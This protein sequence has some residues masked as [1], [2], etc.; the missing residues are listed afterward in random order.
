[1]AAFK[2]NAGLMLEISLEEA[3][4]FI[5]S[6]QFLGSGHGLRNRAGVL[7]A[8]ERLGYIQIDTISVVERAHH[9]VAWSRVPNYHPGHLEKLEQE[10]RIF[11]YW[12]HAA[13]YLPM[14][15]YRFTLF[16]KNH[17]ESGPGHWYAKE[18]QAMQYLLDRIRVEGPLRSRDVEKWEEDAGPVAARS[19]KIATVEKEMD[20]S[21]AGDPI[22]RAFRQLF[23]E[24]KIMVTGREGFQKVYDLAERVLPDSIDTRIPSRQDYLHHLIHQH[25]QAHGLIQ[26]QQPS[27][28]RPVSVAEVHSEMK[29]LLRTGALIE[30]MIRELDGEL[31]YA[32]PMMWENFT[33]QPFRS[34]AVL[35]SPFDNLI[36][37]R[38]R[39]DKLFDLKYTLECYVP[40]TK[41]QFGYF[42]LPLLS[43]TRFI[44]Q[45]DIK[46]ERK[47]KRLLI[48]NLR[49]E[50][51]VR[52]PESHYG[53]LD[54]VLRDFSK[55]NGCEEV[56]INSNL[57]LPDSIGNS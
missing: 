16:H 25:L 57:G 23:M 5:L 53:V 7:S 38:D 30:V 51:W 8:I 41:R 12:A 48:R 4:K 28:L 2:N 22:K 13:A 47:E 29:E 32:D 36:I 44:A 34:R 18:K 17:I 43:G 1:M 50:P 49:W 39:A 14:Q 37:Q 27:Y 54:R 20:K 46:A 45:L 6:T 55:F 35:L 3:R 19:G 21:W 52:K 10:R 26:P 24:G 33:L 42:S 56:C 31:F 11:E 15:D 40:A 9:H